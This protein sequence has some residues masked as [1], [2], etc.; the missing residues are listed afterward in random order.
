LEAQLHS[1]EFKQAIEKIRTTYPIFRK[2]PTPEDLAILVQAGN[3][4]YADKDEILRIILRRLKLDN[5]LF[6][7][8]NFMFWNSLVRIFR[9]KWRNVP[10]PEQLFSR[11]QLDFYHT[12]IAYPLHNRPQKID[13]NLILDTRKKVSKWQQEEAAY[14]E[15]HEELGPDHET[16]QLL[17]EL[18]IT[19]IFPEEKETYLLDLVYRKIINERQYDLLLEVDV[20]KRMN[21]REWAE[22]RGVP[23]A[24][25]RSWHARAEASIRE[26]EEAHREKIK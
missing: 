16:C 20:Y 18:E 13:V 1:P 11:I 26:Y 15:L 2:Y 17:S 24:T 14:Y 22:A 6:P 3:K 8:L 5:T 25:V 21:Q 12:A 4:N 23:Y 7:L 10:N 19:Q 9:R